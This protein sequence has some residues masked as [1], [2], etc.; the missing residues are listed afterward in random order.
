MGNYPNPNPFHLMKKCTKCGETK[1][2]DQYK[3]VSNR[4][5]P[6]QYCLTC[7]TENRR[8]Y[9]QT[10]DYCSRNEGLKRAYGIDSA[11]YDALL[12]KQGGCCAICKSSDPKSPK[13][14]NHWYVDHCHTTGKVRG[15]LCNACNRAL[16]NFQDDVEILQN[17]I[18]YLNQNGP[19]NS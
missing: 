19:L 2:L 18:H 5:V 4:R 12:E 13:R 11:E 17:A 14:V 6:M 16:G 10:G 1:P 7:Y 8:R 3:I 9:K 15:L